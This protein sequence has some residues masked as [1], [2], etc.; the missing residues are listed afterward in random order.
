MS[1]PFLGELRIFSFASAPRGW[2]QCNGQLLPI[3]QN[4]ALFS[5]LGTMYG[6]NGQTNFALPNLQNRVPMHLGSGHT[7]GESAGEANHTLTV[8]E[9]PTHL[10]VA[11][12]SSAAA[13]A[14]A[15]AGNVLAV[16]QGNIY[17]NP[18]Q[19]SPQLTPL[20]PSTTASTGGSQAHNNTQPLLVLNV[21]V[22]LQGV[23]PSQT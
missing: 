4:Q 7:Q 11:Q 2:A 14:N 19:T 6:G 12:A 9:V 1:E 18:N 13:N 17:L 15:A 10:H 3:N 23:F 20:H 5:L 8:N 22:A 16:S 21:C